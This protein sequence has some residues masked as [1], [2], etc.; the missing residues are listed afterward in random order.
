MSPCSRA[1]SSQAE[2][3]RRRSSDRHSSSSSRRWRASAE[4]CSSSMSRRCYRRRPGRRPGPHH[5]GLAEEDL[6]LHLAFVLHRDEAADVRCVYLVVGE[7]YV[8]APD[9]LDVA[10]VPASFEW[11]RDGTCH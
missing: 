6:E 7:L 2:I 5:L 10:P 8:E 11:Y 3:S 1:R 9:D 4:R